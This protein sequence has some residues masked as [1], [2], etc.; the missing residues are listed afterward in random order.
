[1]IEK[2]K[3]SGN[4][5]ASGILVAFSG[6]NLSL[7]NTYKIS[8]NTVNTIPVSTNVILNPTGYFLKPSSTQPIIYT[9]FKS[10]SNISDNSSS[11]LIKLNIYDSNNNL[12]HQDYKAISCENMCGSGVPITP[13]P[14]C[15][16]S[17]TPGPTPTPTPTPSNAPIIPPLNIAVSFDKLVNKS[18]DCKVLVRAKAYGDLN[19]T[20]SYTFETDMQG[21]DLRISNPSG[22][23]TI[24]ENPTY[25]YTYITLPEKYKN[26]AIE[27]GLSDTINT[28]Q[29]A[30]IFVCE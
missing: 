19:K 17:A 11:N 1:M 18:R 26:Y 4:L 16:P 28:V 23:I 12:I 5:C 22:F 9:L 13:T 30:A 10:I 6:I 20:Y 29:S 7:D 27:F 8:F 3:S 21:V 15:T 25:V 14:T 2:I 24:T